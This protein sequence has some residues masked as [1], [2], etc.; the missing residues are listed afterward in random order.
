MTDTRCDDC[1]KL[2]DNGAYIVL[3][4][5]GLG[6][7]T[8]VALRGMDAEDVQIVIDRLDDDG[9]HITDDI[10]PSKALY[11]LSE[12]AIGNIVDNH[13]GNQ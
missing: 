7:Y 6:S 4:R 3:F 10:E 1:K 5:N 12:K 8:A 9:P 13:G 11:R 2:L